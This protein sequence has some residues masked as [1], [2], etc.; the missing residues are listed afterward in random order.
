MSSFINEKGMLGSTNC[1]EKLKKF[2]KYG[3]TKEFYVSFL[4]KLAAIF[5]DCLK[6]IVQYRSLELKSRKKIKG[7]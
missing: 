3:L 5:A 4:M 2:W 1:N 6:G 7:S